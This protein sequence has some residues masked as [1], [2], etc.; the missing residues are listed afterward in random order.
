MVKLYDFVC[1]GWLVFEGRTR[2]QLLGLTFRVRIFL[3]FGSE[4]LGNNNVLI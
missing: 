4:I 1:H 3:K 2:K